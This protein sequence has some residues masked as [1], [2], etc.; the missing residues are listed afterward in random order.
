MK[1]GYTIFYVSDVEASLAFFEEAFGLLRR[2][3]HESGYGE[4]GTGSTALGFASHTLGASNLPNGYVQADRS[5]VPLGMEIALV[6]DDVQSAFDRAVLAG[7]EP[8]KSPIAKPWGQIVAYVR[9]PDGLL[10]ELCTP[11]G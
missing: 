4:I 6:T 10:V 11:M 3:Y 5:A 2:F 7:A 8:L 9:C 1:F